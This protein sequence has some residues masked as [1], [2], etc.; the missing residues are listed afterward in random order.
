RKVPDGLKQL[1]RVR[2]GTC[3]FPG[4]RTNAVISEIDHTKPWA[5]GGPTDH[6]NL[7]HL[8]RRHHMFKTKGFWKACQPSPG[9]I[10]WT[11][12]GGRK[13]RTEPRLALARDTAP[14]PTV[15]A[16]SPTAP[17]PPVP[18]PAVAAP[19]PPAPVPPD[20]GDPDDYGDDPPPF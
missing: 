4:C 11:S 16:P 14:A 5:Q 7:E 19:A 17:A 8:C 2:D 13:Y 9:I 15:P 1:L 18:A 10:E 3:R 12:P 20:A 6:D